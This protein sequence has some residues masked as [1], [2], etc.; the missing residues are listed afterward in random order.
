MRRHQHPAALRVVVH[1]RPALHQLRFVPA[2]SHPLPADASLPWPAALS[3]TRV[4][5]RL[6]CPARSRL[7][8]A[9]A[10]RSIISHLPLSCSTPRASSVQPAPNSATLVRA[11][12][13]SLPVFSAADA[14]PPLMTSCRALP[15]FPAASSPC[16]SAPHVDARPHVPSPVSCSS[17]RGD[18]LLRLP[19]VVEEHSV[20]AMQERQRVLAV[21]RRL[22]LHPAC[23][24]GQCVVPQQQGVR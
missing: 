7:L 4:F 21:Q 19:V 5:H 11:A 17:G 10:Y 16:S 3:S 13:E 8:P 20:S 9:R 24:G 6:Q 18:D 1:Q 23:G 14:S 2:R 15:T 22:P 12:H